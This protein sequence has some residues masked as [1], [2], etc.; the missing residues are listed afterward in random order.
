MFLGCRLATLCAF[1]SIFFLAFSLAAA[2]APALVNPHIP[3][4]PCDSCHTKVPTASEGQAGRYHLIKETIDATCHVCHEKTCCKPGT[5]HSMNHPSGVDKWDTKLFR[6]PKTLPL[7]N[8]FIT[9]ST[10]HMHSKPEGESYKMVRMV[11]RDGRRI[12]WSELCLDCHIG[13]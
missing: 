3:P 2:P 8:G 7:F 10:C 9:C 1:A 5:F 11:R 6:K 13:Y 4:E 12:D